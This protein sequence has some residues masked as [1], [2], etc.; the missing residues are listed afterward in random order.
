[1]MH[2]IMPVNQITKKSNHFYIQFYANIAKKHKD[3]RF[4]QKI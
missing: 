4:N 2:V 1:M 3:F